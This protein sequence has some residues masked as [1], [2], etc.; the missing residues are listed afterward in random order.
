M[1]ISTTGLSIAVGARYDES[2]R[3]RR[4]VAA[5]AARIE[6]L[7]RSQVH[8]QPYAVRAVSSE[9]ESREQALAARRADVT[10]QERIDAY[11]QLFSM[12]VVMRDGVWR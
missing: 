4:E 6:A 11:R 3:I 7:T 10:L 2:Y 1:A 12:S 9:M 5:R 8:A